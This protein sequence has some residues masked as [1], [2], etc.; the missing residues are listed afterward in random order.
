MPVLR[1]NVPP[2]ETHL[3]SETR[4]ATYQTSALPTREAG[5]KAVPWA[6][7]VSLRPFA[8]K[9]HRLEMLHQKI[10]EGSHLCGN[11]LPIRVSQINGQP[12]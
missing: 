5:R 6:R 11:E 4:R 2:S 10:D 8:L 7:V 12:R 1:M 3:Q 9:A